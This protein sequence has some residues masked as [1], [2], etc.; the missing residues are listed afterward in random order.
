MM[1]KIIIW[2][3]AIGWDEDAICAGTFWDACPVCRFAS[4]SV[5]AY[6]WS[7][8]NSQQRRWF[9]LCI[10][11]V[12]ARGPSASHSHIHKHRVGLLHFPI[13]PPPSAFSVSL[14]PSICRRDEVTICC[15]V[16][17]WKGLMGREKV[18]VGESTQCCDFVIAVKAEVNWG[19]LRW[20]MGADG[21][22]AVEGREGLTGIERK[23][24][25]EKNEGGKGAM[26][27]SLQ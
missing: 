3:S 2:P 17:A 19:E 12:Y 4:E 21:V 27:L 23:T 13:L 5:H 15:S 6:M 22:T 16:K 20:D 9:V 14:Y 11:S 7:N 26:I 25:K 1:L 8:F 10:F 24:E 18:R